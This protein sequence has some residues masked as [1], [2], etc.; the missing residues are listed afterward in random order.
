MD[1]RYTGRAAPDGLG[2]VSPKALDPVPGGLQVDRLRVQGML[3]K[4][5]LGQLDRVLVAGRDRPVDQLLRTQGALAGA[6]ATAGGDTLQAP[7]ELNLMRRSAGSLERKLGA[8]NY[9]ASGLTASVER[10]LPVVREGEL[11]LL[12]I[13]TPTLAEDQDELDV[14]VVHANG[15][16]RLRELVPAD[17]S[18]PVTVLRIPA[19]LFEAGIHAAIVRVP[20][21]PPNAIRHFDYTFRVN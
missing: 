16:R 8:K 12:A 20:G 2:P 15:R 17:P 13:P 21:D 5:R 3:P 1:C 14:Q 11:L 4:A 7:P 18:Q 10:E 19:A 6:R 9:A